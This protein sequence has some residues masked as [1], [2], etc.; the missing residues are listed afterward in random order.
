MES[1]MQTQPCFQVSNMETRGSYKGHQF[2]FIQPKAFEYFGEELPEECLR[3][4]RFLDGKKSK[5]RTSPLNGLEMKEAAMSTILDPNLNSD[6]IL[7]PH[8]RKRRGL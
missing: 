3:V 2:G 4:R 7:E 6:V 1:M 8:V 5:K